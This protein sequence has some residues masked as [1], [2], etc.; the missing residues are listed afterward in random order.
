[1]PSQTFWWWSRT[2]TTDVA[3]AADKNVSV[4]AIPYPRNHHI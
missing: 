1:M 3:D 4:A 2:P